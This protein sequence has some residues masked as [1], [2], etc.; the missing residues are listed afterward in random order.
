MIL[1]YHKLVKLVESGVI[2]APVDQ[3]NGSSIDIRL[4]HI[5]RKEVFGSAMRKVNLAQGYSID[6]DETELPFT[7]MPD[8]ILLGSS[9][10][11]LNMPLNL[12]AEYSLKSTLGRNFLGHELAGW[13]DPGFNGRITLELKNNSQ[14]HKLILEPGMKIGQIKFFEHQP[15]PLEH[16]YRTKGQYNG[17]AKAQPAGRL[18]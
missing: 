6:T 18:K 14:F 12:S 3:I 8:S 16:S 15:V 5:V 1:S 4:H 2:D 17:Q 7:M 11:M 9:I 10:E 13:I